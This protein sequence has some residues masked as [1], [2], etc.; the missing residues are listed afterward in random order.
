MLFQGEVERAIT[1]VYN[2]YETMLSPY[3]PW[4][5][6][7]K[8]LAAQRAAEV[9]AL[10]GPQV[11]ST[12]MKEQ[13]QADP[14]AVGQPDD[15]G[16]PYTPETA[17]TGTLYRMKDIEPRAGEYAADDG[18]I[19]WETYNADRDEFLNNIETLSETVGVPITTE[20]YIKFRF[21]YAAPD[22]I[23]Y[24][25]YKD[26]RDAGWEVYET[27]NKRSDSFDDLVLWAVEQQYLKDLQ[28]GFT[29]LEADKLRADNMTQYRREGLP[30]E[31]RE[32][33]LG[34][35]G[36]P[37]NLTRFGSAVADILGLDPTE[38]SRYVLARELNYTLPDIFGEQ[39]LTEKMRSDL[40]DY[41]YNL[42]PNEKAKVRDFLGMDYFELPDDP[43]ELG[44]IYRRVMLSVNRASLMHEGLLTYIEPNTIPVLPVWSELTPEEQAD[45]EQLRV[46]SYR[47]NKARDAGIYGT[48][49][50]LMTKYLST[51]TSASGK[52]W[53]FLNTMSLNDSAFDDPVIG[54][55]MNKATREILQPTDEQYTIALEYLQEHIDQLIDRDKTDLILAHPDWYEL[56]QQQRGEFD[57]H[58]DLELEMLKGQYYSIYYKDRDKWEQEHPE[59]WRRLK[60][61][62][63]NENARALRYPYY[64]YFFKDY[65]YRNRYGRATPNEVSLESAPALS[66]DYMKAVQDMDRYVNGETDEWTDGMTQFF[67]PPPS[68][69]EGSPLLATSIRAKQETLVGK[70]QPMYNPESDEALTDYAKEWARRNVTVSEYAPAMEGRIG[71]TYEKELGDYLRTHKRFTLLSADKQDALT[72]RH[73]LA[74]TIDREYHVSGDP[75]SWESDFL[76]AVEQW[77][78][79]DERVRRAYDYGMWVAKTYGPINAAPEAYAW[80]FSEFADNPSSIPPELREYFAPYLNLE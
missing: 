30:F 62:I 13:Y 42:V 44:Q 10:A 67:G 37:I 16:K 54:P 22:E 60:F 63:D 7:Y 41:Y 35:Y 48:W 64:A 80:L 3:H 53:G 70:R 34:E 66:D 5:A 74:H 72:Y 69:P 61:Y 32:Q 33:V 78:G 71:Y 55:L 12:T 56:A 11:P 47:Y 26:W 38:E 46:D 76:D 15:F 9:D 58:R 31:Y 25:L 36:Q 6:E 75:N 40:F 21:R 14:I 4:D 57:R 49:T 39:D 19:D 73:E 1:E 43:E 52:F 45:L 27:L 2:R 79:A 29:P 51:E 50:P 8:R 28:A 24:N 59:E 23:A 17:H 68:G 77:R 65:Y 18:E 20:E